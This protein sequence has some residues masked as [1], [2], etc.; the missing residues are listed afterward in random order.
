MSPELKTLETTLEYF[1]NN[2]GKYDSTETVHHHLKKNVESVDL[3][4]YEMVC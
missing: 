2:A 3:G 1:S 4:I